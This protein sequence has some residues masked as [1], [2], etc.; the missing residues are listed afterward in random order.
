MTVEFR[1]VSA[2]GRYDPEPG[3]V[4]G[5]VMDATGNSLE[6]IVVEVLWGEESA[7]CPLLSARHDAAPGGAAQTTTGP[8][9]QFLFQVHAPAV[10]VAIRIANS[11]SQVVSDL[12]T[13]KGSYDVFF[14]RNNPP[15]SRGE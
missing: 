15:E 13:G 4:Y 6:G 12:M 5:R 2:Y 11:T 7:Q 1:V 3:A 10:C 8:D 14:K 9:G